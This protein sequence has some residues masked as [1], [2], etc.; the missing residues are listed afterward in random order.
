M[1][2]SYFKHDSTGYVELMKSQAVDEM[3]L[4]YGSRAAAQL[5]S[6]YETKLQTGGKDR[7][8]VK[9]G[10][11]TAKARKE[12]LANNTVWKVVSNL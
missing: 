1:S 4:N 6:D 10:G 5:G 11:T 8:T 2:K 12:N 3:L 9:V 7:H